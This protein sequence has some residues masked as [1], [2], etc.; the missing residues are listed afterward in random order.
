MFRF[1]IQVLVLLTLVV[2]VMLGWQLKGLA[3]AG[4]E[5]NEVQAD[6]ADLAGKRLE[7]M[8]SRIKSLVVSSTD[9]EFPTRMQPAPLFR[10]D[11]ETRGYVDGTIWR[12]GEKGRPLAIVT[13]ELHPRYLGGGSR[14]VYDF[15]SLTERSF[16]ARS[17]DV[18]GWTPGGSAVA[19]CPLK[20][21]P[22][23]ATKAAA[24]LIQLKQQ[25]RRF[26]GT[27][28]VRELD[29]TSVQLRLLPRE[30]DRYS[31]AAHELADG[32][33]FL[34]VNGR[35][36]A[37]LLIIET[38]G[39]SWQYCVGRLSAPSKLEVRLD[40]DLVWSQPRL[41]SFEWAQP[42]TASNTAA[43]FP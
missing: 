29:E 31:P 33:V 26:S 39:K 37:L 21:A 27:Q 38:D 2:A 24:R 12:L 4:Q 19:L 5:A 14:I 34:L 32:A 36:P 43:E 23:P 22:S 17:P 10:Y 7:V 35:N 41:T 42:Y 20:D 18:A 11:D 25:A 28:V 30:I 1:T 15:L 3:R 13:A 8:S 40:G 9:A 6:K 16:T